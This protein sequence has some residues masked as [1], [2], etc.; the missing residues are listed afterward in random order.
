M[1]DVSLPSFCPSCGSLSF[2][3]Y[4]YNSNTY[5]S[6]PVFSSNLSSY[7]SFVMQ[8]MGKSSLV[9]ELAVSTGHCMF[10]V[11][12]TPRVP[13]DIILNGI[14]GMASTGEINRACQ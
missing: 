6:L 7:I 2:T 11:L 10:S 3:D 12:C 14:K 5:T 9:H 1:V 13:H 4:V 8:E